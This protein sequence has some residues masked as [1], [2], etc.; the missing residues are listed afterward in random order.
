MPFASLPP[1]K[2]TVISLFPSGGDDT[3]RI[4][5]AL[6]QVG[7]AGGGIVELSAGTFTISASLVHK[8][9]C[10]LRG[11]GNSTII[12]VAGGSGT[13][14]A[15][16]IG[17]GDLTNGLGTFCTVSDMQISYGGG[18]PK[19]AGAGIRV[20]GCYFT[21]LERIRI[22][23]H[24]IGIEVQGYTT[25][26]HMEH[27]NVN[28]SRSHG[29]WFHANDNGGIYLRDSVLEYTGAGLQDGLGAGIFWSQRDDVNLDNV[30]VL[31]SPALGS[32]RIVPDVGVPAN[33]MGGGRF[34]NC[35]FDAGTGVGVYIDN[36]NSSIGM[37][38]FVN[39]YAGYCVSHGVHIK[40]VNSFSWI[41][42]DI[43]SNLGHGFFIEGR[44]NILIQAVEIYRNGGGRGIKLASGVSGVRI[45]DNRISDVAPGYGGPPAVLHQEYGIEY[46]GSHTNCIITGNDLRGNNTA[47]TTGTAPSGIVANNLP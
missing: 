38:G 43:L 42:G 15:I 1:Y 7:A 45:Q 34:H 37:L 20:N 35:K 3:T 32:L 33:D 16:Q 10:S 25:M 40:G 27:I 18:A 41:G 46:G 39:C 13:I 6:N 14:D 4:Q 12:S 9:Y 23:Y 47:A 5:A 2:S 19:T 24:Y 36:T 17:T 8:S 22:V 30:E 21:R 29:F 11:Q 31:S 28:Q 26:T 44:T